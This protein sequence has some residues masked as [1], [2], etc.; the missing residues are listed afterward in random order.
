MDGFFNI[1]LV[2]TL[3]QHLLGLGYRA[4]RIETFRAGVGAIHDRVA[5]IQAKGVLKI[6]QTFT[7]RL[8]PAVNQPAVSSK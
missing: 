3:G 4:G 7:R 5:A 8:V 2:S 1:L 6:I